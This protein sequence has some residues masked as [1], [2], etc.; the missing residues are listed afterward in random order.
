MGSSTGASVSTSTTTSA[1]TSTST[2]TGS[3]NLGGDPLSLILLVQGVAVTSKLSS[4]PDSYGDSFADSFSM[5]NLQVIFSFFCYVFMHIY[6]YTQTP[7][8]YLM[9]MQCM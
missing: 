1:T 2:S 8:S 4:M 7:N 3:S 6:I 5:F 9:M